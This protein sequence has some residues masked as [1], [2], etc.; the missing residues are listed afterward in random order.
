LQEPQEAA[1]YL[2]AALAD[3]DTD[4]R[5]FS[6]KGNPE[7][8]S[9]DKLLLALEPMTEPTGAP[10]SY[11]FDPSAVRRMRSSHVE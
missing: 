9:L 2:D 5:T 10:N 8:A 6:D 1:A 3:E 4:Y 7:F 11:G